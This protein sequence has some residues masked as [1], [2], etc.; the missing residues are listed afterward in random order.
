[1][2]ICV[3]Q[4][5]PSEGQELAGELTADP[6]RFTDQHTFE[7]RWIRKDTAAEQIDAAVDEGFDF[8][9]NFMW[10]QHEDEVAGIDAC[11]YLECLGLPSIGQRS[12]ILERNKND[13]YELARALGAPK[14]PGISEHPLFVRPASSYAKKPTSKTPLCR[15]HD[16]LLECLKYLNE[17]LKPSRIIAKRFTPAT[18]TI[19]DGIHI[20]DDVAVQEYVQ[21]WRYSVVVIEVGDFPVPL[22]PEKYVYSSGL[23]PHEESLG[24]FV[25]FQRDKRIT[26]LNRKVVPELFAKLQEI[27]VQAFRANHMAGQSWCSVDI[28]VPATGEPIV[29]HV[30][31]MPYLFRSPDHEWEDHAVRK[32]FPGGHRALINVLIASY[33]IYR[34]AEIDRQGMIAS[35]YSSFGKQ[36]NHALNSHEAS[37]IYKKILS[38]VDLSGSCLDLGSGTGALGRLFSAEK[39]RKQQQRVPPSSNLSSPEGST[40]RSASTDSVIFKG[41]TDYCRQIDAYSEVSQGS[42]QT[43]LSSLG[44]YDHIVSVGCYI[45]FLPRRSP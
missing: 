39:N 17:A 11:R 12:Q 16:E 28:R 43:V 9:F 19:I 44:P 15:N 33:Q 20:H 41:T 29:I 26:L 37:G 22:T 31:P 40:S 25:N 10:G 3:L 42:I 14:V 7:H 45:L 30:H 32:A 34:Q 18:S 4:S 1:M 2:R 24:F 13:F 6:S 35:T 36:Y 5:A 23:I 38:L 21:G 27:A 8:Y